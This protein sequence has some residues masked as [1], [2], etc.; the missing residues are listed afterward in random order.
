M[1]GGLG[2]LKF[3][4]NPDLQCLSFQFRGAGSSV[5]TTGVEFERI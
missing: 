4:K 1:Q 2:I 3:D 5:W